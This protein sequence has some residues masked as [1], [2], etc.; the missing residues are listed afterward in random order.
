LKQ[1]ATIKANASLLDMVTILEQQRHLKDFMECKNS[2]IASLTEEK[3]E[4]GM[5]INKVGVHNPR[6][7]VKNPPFYYL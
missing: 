7:Y 3:N 5:Y 4:E 6:S 1:L 2:T